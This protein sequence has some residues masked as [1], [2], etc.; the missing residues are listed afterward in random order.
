MLW[1]W[2]SADGVIGCRLYAPGHSCT[3]FAVCFFFFFLFYSAWGHSLTLTV[4][5]MLLITHFTILWRSCYFQNGLLLKGFVWLSRPKKSTA[6]K[7]RLE[8]FSRRVRV[9]NTAHSQTLNFILREQE[10]KVISGCINQHQTF[11]CQF[12][13]RPNKLLLLD[14]WFSLKSK[15]TFSLSSR[16]S[17]TDV[18]CFSL[19][20]ALYDASPSPKT[21]WFYSFVFACNSELWADKMITVWKILI[22]P[23]ILANRRL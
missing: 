1:A 20:R 7:S 8:M 18:K 14:M 6:E 16:W 15:R 9:L 13:F 3:L 17:I 22:L 21:I 19:S 11:S 12:A 4:F 2:R 5:I 10:D 23:D